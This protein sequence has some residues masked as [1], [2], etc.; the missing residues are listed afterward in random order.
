MNVVREIKVYNEIWLIKFVVYVFVKSGD[1]FYDG[2]KFLLRLDLIKKKLKFFYL[3][4]YGKYVWCLFFC[5]FL[6]VFVY[7]F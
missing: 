5:N 6:C 4:L 2:E 3:Y 1:C 7:V